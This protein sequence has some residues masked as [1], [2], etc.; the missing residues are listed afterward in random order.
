MSRRLGLL[1]A[2][3]ALLLFAL[4]TFWLRPPLARGIHR[5]CESRLP[6]LIGRPVTLEEV[7]IH[8]LFLSV[9]LQGLRIGE[10]EHPVF[11]CRRWVLRPRPFHLERDF[12]WLKPAIGNSFVD[13]PVLRPETA[14]GPSGKAPALS[15]MLTTLGGRVAWLRHPLRWNHGTVHLPAAADREGLSVSDLSGHFDWNRRGVVLHA[16]GDVPFGDARFSLHVAPEGTWKLSIVSEKIDLG[17]LPLRGGQGRLAG[18]LSGKG[19][20][21]GTVAQWD[22]KNW[23][24]IRWRIAGNVSNGSW[25]PPNSTLR[26]PFEGTFGLDRDKLAL[27]HFK[28]LK[29]ISV[30]GHCSNPFGPD[31][32][33]DF[34]LRGQKMD[35][36]GL[37]S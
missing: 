20:A 33:M 13:G 16:R 31:A 1:V 2:G 22:A 35:T 32:R 21:Q 15:Q 6:P 5:L 26:I 9:T 37:L 27:S 34:S 10:A 7:R 14:A 28:L 36:S 11:V 12:P 8:P 24:S 25:S 29:K 3:A 17:K 30:E 23:K 19:E 4:W 18:V